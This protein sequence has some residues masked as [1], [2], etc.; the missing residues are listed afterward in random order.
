M[1]KQD[2]KCLEEA[3]KSARIIMAGVCD[4][5]Y[6][7][8]LDKA[9][10]KDNLDIVIHNI[11]SLIT[12]IEIASAV[13]CADD[14]EVD[15][16]HKVRKLIHTHRELVLNAYFGG[17]P[18]PGVEKILKIKYKHR[19]KKSCYSI[20]AKEHQKIYQLKGSLF[21]ESKESNKYARA[22]FIEV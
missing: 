2:I 22:N 12:P 7:S 13:Y 1:K 8:D 14:V 4:F 17:D 21:V 3:L 6:N 16:V 19:L 9:L 10:M 15:V 18:K 5:G 20:E 11:N